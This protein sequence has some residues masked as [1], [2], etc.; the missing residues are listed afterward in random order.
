M[1]LFVLLVPS[2]H[3]AQAGNHSKQRY[4]R[5][6]RP[7]PFS[8]A[9]RR[10]LRFV[11]RWGKKR[12]LKLRHDSRLQRAARNVLRRNDLNPETRLVSA[13]RI[14][15]RWGWTD[16][17]LAAVSIWV[18]KGI[19][20]WST[21]ADELDRQL[22]QVEMNRVGLA[23]RHEGKGIVASV[24][25][26][27]KLIN[28][29]PLVRQI[30]PGTQLTIKGLLPPTLPQKAALK[31]V[32]I[33]VRGDPASRTLPV[34]Q[35]LFSTTVGTGGQGGIM[36]FQFLIDRGR[37]PEVAATFPL[38]VGRS[39]DKHLASEDVIKAPAVNESD[40]AALTRM[41]L[42]IRTAQGLHIPA[43]SSRLA[44]IALGHAK[45]MQTHHFFAHRSPYSGD[46]KDRLRTHKI[47]FSRVVENIATAD[48]V[49]GVL[50]AWMESPSHR[51]NILDAGVSAFGLGVVKTGHAPQ[52]LYAVLLMA[53]LVSEQENTI[54][55]ELERRALTRINQSRERLGLAHFY[56][57]AQLKRL[58]QQHSRSLARVRNLQ[59]APPQ[60]ELV[61]AVFRE[62]DVNNASAR[63]FLV[64]TPEQLQ[65]T[66][67]SVVGYTLAGIGVHPQA[68]SHR[69]W[70]TLIV[71]RE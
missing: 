61:D 37:G 1:L 10:L 44:D 52:K 14:A 4:E 60:Q 49:T 26:S 71:A 2:T 16:G 54:V 68:Q 56:A 48:S 11:R 17:Q 21:L 19:M 57:D 31:L 47:E 30:R 43:H 63:V 27:R 70:V 15:Q 65:L 7:L 40:E 22:G 29:V 41:L 13:R 32:T 46:A 58:A 59:E 42:E 5:Y 66:E 38:G 33:G 55:A 18:P 50:S 62:R 67:Q 35:R 23:T 20:A 25:L 8:D 6:V 36:E 28:L 39:P 24:L 9:D 69:L 53:K 45:D 64:E 12:S 34:A 51:A 3:E